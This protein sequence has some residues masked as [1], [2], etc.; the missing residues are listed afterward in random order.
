MGYVLP[1]NYIVTIDKND[2]LCGLFEHSKK[3][4]APNLTQLV[5]FVVVIATL[6]VCKIYRASFKF[7]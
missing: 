5:K 6:E 7:I 3:V 2:L 1:I 4:V